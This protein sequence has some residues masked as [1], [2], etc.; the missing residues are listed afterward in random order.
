MDIIL[1]GGLLIGLVVAYLAPAIIAAWRNH[2]NANPVFIVN[3][4]LGWTVIGW[5]LCLAWSF[6]ANTNKAR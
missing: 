5:V 6:S 3:L 2:V 1:A 4:F